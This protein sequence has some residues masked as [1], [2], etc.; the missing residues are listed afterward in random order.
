ME[1]LGVYIFE[2]ELFW[3]FYSK[4]KV[5]TNGVSRTKV[6]L[7][8]KARSLKKEW[9]IIHPTNVIPIPM[10]LGLLTQQEQIKVKTMSIW[11]WSE[12]I[13]VVKKLQSSTEITHYKMTSPQG[14]DELFW[15]HDHE[16][17]NDWV[18]RLTMAVEVWDLNADKLFKIAKLNLR[19]RAKEW[20]K[21]L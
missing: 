16:D 21:R 18:E 20:F 4:S 14:M 10:E 12:G 8:D 19:S 7:T 15:G 17:V 1:I 5:V 2:N 3:C 6:Y 11:K 13:C 9:C